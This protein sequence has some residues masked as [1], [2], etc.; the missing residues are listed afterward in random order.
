MKL[1]PFFVS[2]AF[3]V[4]ICAQTPLP[5]KPLPP[6][7]TVTPVTPPASA[8]PAVPVPTD[9]NTVILA[10]GADQLTLG[11]YNE[12]IDT[13]PAQYQT[14]ARGPQKRQIAD[15]IVRLRIMAREGQKRG[16][17]KDPVVQ[18]QLAFQREQILAN[19]AFVDMQKKVVV[20]D[21]DARKYYDDHKSEYESIKGAHIL[22]RYKGSPVPMRPGTKEMTEE[23]SLAK[24][25]EL[26]RK[27]DGGAD[28]G[29]LAKLESDD[30]GSGANGGDLGTFKRGQMVG[31]FETAAF[32]APVGKVTDPIK[33]QFGYHLIK[34]ESKDATTFEA[35][36]PGIVAKLG[37]D[38]AKKEADDLHDKTKV[39][40]N[41]AF[42]GPA[43]PTPLAMPVTPQ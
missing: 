28:F 43:T 33:T 26:K 18:R 19:A 13:L 41:D 4:P 42:F 31:P 34:I 1:L 37:P 39:V 3:A 36:K 2:A 11:Q 17:E 40:Y 35:A 25:T 27:L 6:N 8:A 38:T 21:A 5:P 15:Q 30:I 9:P 29:T 22:I 23:E 20:S 24:A 7:V 10:I 14:A 16:L 32:A 12:I